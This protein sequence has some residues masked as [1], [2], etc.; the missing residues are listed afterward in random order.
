VRECYALLDHQ[1]E[2]CIMPMADAFR[3]GYSEAAKGSEPTPNLQRVITSI[4]LTDAPLIKVAEVAIGPLVV[5]DVEFLAFDIYQEGR[6]DVVLGRSILKDFRVV[7]DSPGK[8]MQIQKE[9]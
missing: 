6:C 5:K 9:G 1:S 4:V 2:Y 8:R 3:L 7:I